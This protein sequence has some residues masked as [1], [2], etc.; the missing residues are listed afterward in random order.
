MLNTN[1]LEV[2]TALAGMLKERGL[3]IA[4]ASGSI[5]AGMDEI[6]RAHV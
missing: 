1:E 5:I 3:A 4:P 6:G 2:A